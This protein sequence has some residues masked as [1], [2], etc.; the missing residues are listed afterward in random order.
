MAT[1][2]T[3]REVQLVDRM[4]VELR[5]CSDLLADLAESLPPGPVREA[6]QGRV[7]CQRDLLL[8][9]VMASTGGAV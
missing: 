6:L 5:H 8:D 2:L 7:V 9:I 4:I 3:E 1:V